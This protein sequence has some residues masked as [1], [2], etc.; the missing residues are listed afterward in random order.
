MFDADLRPSSLLKRA[1]FA[2]LFVAVAGQTLHSKDASLTAIELFDGPNGAAFVQVTG[3]LIN[4]KAEVRSCGGATKISKS[5]YGKLAKIPLTSSVTSLERDAKGTMTLT[6]G[7]ASECVVPSNLKF[8]KDESLTPAQLADRAV[9]Q[10]Q[11]ASSSPAGTTEV[12]A[13]KPTVKI[14]FVQAPDIELGEYLRADRAHSVGQWQEYLSR[15]PKA[16][17]T[18]A[19]KQ[20]LAALLLKEGDDGLAAYRSSATTG[21]V[22]YAQLSIL[23]S[24]PGARSAAGE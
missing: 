22:A 21:S 18:D 4:G 1:S 10:G 5:S 2:L 3:L 8:D 11:V 23:A 6:R 13:F 19:G 9:L 12:P 17:H 14:V 7:T 16:A 20:S 15:Y 24:G